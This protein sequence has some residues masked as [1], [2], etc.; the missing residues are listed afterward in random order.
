MIPNSLRYPFSRWLGVS[1]DCVGCEL[2]MS[3]ADKGGIVL[4]QVEVG[5]NRRPPLGAL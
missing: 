3:R 5:V 2:H 1:G 4:Q